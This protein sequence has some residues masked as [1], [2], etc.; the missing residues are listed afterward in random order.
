MNK[1][2]Y[3]IAA[4]VGAA[5]ILVSSATAQAATVTANGTPAPVASDSIAGWPG[6]SRCHVRNSS[7]DRCRYGS[8]F[9]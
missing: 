9:V 6:S 5:V 7:S 1:G 8:G 4:G 3:Q 2:I